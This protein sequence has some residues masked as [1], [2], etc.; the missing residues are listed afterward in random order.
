MKKIILISFI[1]LTVFLFGCQQALTDNPGIHLTPEEEAKGI[2]VSES[3][4]KYLLHPS[5][6]FNLNWEYVDEA[7]LYDLKDKKK[8]IDNPK[9]VSV[10][11]ADE[12]I[13]DDQ[14]VQVLIHEGVKRVYPIKIQDKHNIINDV[15]ADTPVLIAWCG[16]CGTGLVL[17]RT[18]DGQV[19]EFG[20]AGLIYNSN[21]VMYDRNTDSIWTLA[22]ASAVYGELTGKRLKV[23]ESD[24]ALWG[25]WKTAHS[26]SEV[27]S[28]DTGFD[29]EY[30]YNYGR[31]T[32]YVGSPV[33]FFPIENKDTRIHL[34]DVVFGIEVDGV[35]KA[36]REEDLKELGTIEDTV[37][38]VRV[39]V[40]RDEVGQV[41]ITNLDTNE[42]IIKERDLWFGWSAFHPETE[43]YTR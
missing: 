28:L 12:W 35:F 5:K 4:V 25:D 1:I 14:L 9:F 17:E 13:N 38:G 41:R 8:F 19:L 6:F 24:T 7:K 15:V 22:G 26:D 30:K 42:P 11:E 31:Y 32:D 33:L 39:K 34:K 27:L 2:K 43:L 23:I 40:T 37:N 18:L 21:V 10:Q 29:I 3:G 20:N 36:Y 16:L